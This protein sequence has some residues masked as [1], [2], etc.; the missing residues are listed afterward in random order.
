MMRALH[1]TS[2]RLLDGGLGAWRRA[3]GSLDSGVPSARPVQPPVVGD[4]GGKLD[5]DGVKRAREAGALLVDS[6]DPPRYQGIEE[7][8]DPIAGHIPGALNLPWQGA[9][10]ADGYALDTEAQ[11]ARLRVLDRD[12]DLVVYCGSGVTACV[13]LLALHLVGDDRARLYPG[14]WSDW[15]SYAENVQALS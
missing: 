9:T 7:P 15:C 10:D 5:V 13:N 2:V 8:I 6:R 12:R 14:S 4:Y 11:K 1:Y 3:G